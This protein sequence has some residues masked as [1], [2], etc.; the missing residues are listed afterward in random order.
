MVGG[1]DNIMS[2]IIRM[3]PNHI[4]R[5][6]LRA[7]CRRFY[8]LCND[9]RN[10]KSFLKLVNRQAMNTPNRKH[11]GA[12]SSD[13]NI[14]FFED[15]LI[16]KTSTPSVEIFPDSVKNIQLDCACDE[17]NWLF[18]LIDLFGKRRFD[19]LEFGDK[20]FSRENDVTDFED[21]LLKMVECFKH[22][23]ITH[24][25]NFVMVLQDIF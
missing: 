22:V 23:K 17:I 19:T 7:T 18:S 15:T 6:N 12:F 5:Y 21:K 20:F 3:L 16:I 13:Q 10:F 24:K 8:N 25:K 1:S 2:L 11:Q 4:D 9:R 14:K